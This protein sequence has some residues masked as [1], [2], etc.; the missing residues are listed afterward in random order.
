MTHYALDDLVR[1][2]GL[3]KR[4]IRFYIQNGLVP[5]P[6]GE[7]RGAYYLDGH[8]EA[9]LRIKR[10]TAEGFS[11]ERV[12]ALLAS[13]EELPRETPVPG[14]VSVRSH[15]FIAP[16]VELTVDPL[17]AALSTHEMRRLVGR[18]LEELSVIHSEKKE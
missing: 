8:L 1:I 6:E 9:L 11:L 7:R 13:P 5:H 16:G 12:K 3:A 15:V 17:E 2:T 10:L 4:T 18:V 14:R